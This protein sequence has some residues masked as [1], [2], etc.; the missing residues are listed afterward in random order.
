M[1]AQHLEVGGILESERE[2]QPLL[3]RAQ[4]PARP[5][6]AGLP[7][8]SRLA[9][10]WLWGLCGRASRAEVPWD[11]RPGTG[12]C[13]R[14][15][16]RLCRRSYSP[17]TGFRIPFCHPEPSPEA[18]AAA[19]VSYRSTADS[20]L[21]CLS[22]GHTPAFSSQQAWS[23]GPASALP[24]CAHAFGWQTWIRGGDECQD[25]QA[26]AGARPPEK[27]V[28]GHAATLGDATYQQPGPMS[29]WP[30]HRL[31]VTPRATSC[32]QG[33]RAAQPGIWSS[34]PSLPAGLSQGP[35][36]TGFQRRPKAI[37]TEC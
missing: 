10:C 8:L 9:P 15:L 31:L 29:V 1:Q 7:W 23:P 17:K 4:K 26:R 12:S 30:G 13:W 19:S 2:T 28:M 36:A 35:V 34:G 24:A 22:P 37:C 21:P 20:Q 14:G 27:P 5:S 16:T 33:C 32:D 6:L 11:S 18:S 25:S 3:G